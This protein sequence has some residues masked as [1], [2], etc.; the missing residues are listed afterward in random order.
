MNELNPLK[1]VLESSDSLAY[2]LPSIY[3]RVVVS[4][5][6]ANVDVSTL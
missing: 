2:T 4:C 1:G 6:V 5:I 3:V